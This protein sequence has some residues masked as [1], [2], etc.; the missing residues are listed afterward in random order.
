MDDKKTM[1]ISIPI[2]VLEKLAHEANT[3]GISANTYA[4]MILVAAVAK[5]DK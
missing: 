2:D 1:H 5:E 3:K 4:R